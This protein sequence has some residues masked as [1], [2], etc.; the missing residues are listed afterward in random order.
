MRLSLLVVTTLLV[1]CAAE[2]PSH[3]LAPEGPK[4][5][6]F[7]L[8]TAAAA[9]PVPGE[10]CVSFEQ[11]FGFTFGT[12]MK[13]AGPIW[14]NATWAT[15]IP[16]SKLRFSVVG[17]S[18]D[19]VYAQA[20]GTSPLSVELD[21]PMALDLSLGAVPVDR[22]GGSAGTTIKGTLTGPVREWTR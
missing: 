12:S 20:E 18:G 22:P 21:L 9:C 11:D 1:G 5:L 4:E 8:K 13:H 16:A 6:P 3:E 2:A 17:A 14:L 15:A 19:P 10:G 7:S